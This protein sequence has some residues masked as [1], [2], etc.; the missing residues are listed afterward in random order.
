MYAISNDKDSLN[1][2]PNILPCKISYNGPVNASERYWAIK[3]DE[4]GQKTAYFR[5]R[6]L[7]GQDLTLPKGYSGEE[8]ILVSM[9]RH[10]LTPESGAVI[11]KTTD[12]LPQESKPL[13]R[14]D[15]DDLSADEDQEAPQEVK[16]MQEAASFEKITVWGHEA[17][18]SG[19]ED[20]YLKGVQ[21]WMLFAKSVSPL[22]SPTLNAQLMI[23]DP[24]V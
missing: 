5:G 17:L 2:T 9:F 8:N 21:E 15:E 11:Q 4:S 7:V 1:V 13:P 18:P 20:P 19:S 6:K 24:L 23:L 10:V 12:L 22:S 3:N 16:I 14:M